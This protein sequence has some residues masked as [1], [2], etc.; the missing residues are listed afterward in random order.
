MPTFDE[1]SLRQIH[2]D[3]SEVMPLVFELARAKC[4]AN[5]SEAYPDQGYEFTDTGIS[6]FSVGESRY[7][8]G[9]YLAS[10]SITYEEIANAEATKAFYK[11]VKAERIA[12][13]KAARE[14]WERTQYESLR[15]KFEA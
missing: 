2:K 10:I 8:M 12:T 5:P 15:K 13:E 4:E 3:L 7:D 1:A 6:L 9:T 11:K 14:E